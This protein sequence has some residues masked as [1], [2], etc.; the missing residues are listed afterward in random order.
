MNS[1]E[2]SLV[3]SV[4]HAAIGCV[5]CGFEG[6]CPRDEIDVVFELQKVDE[7]WQ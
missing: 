2:L 1:V 6:T 7:C 4:H 5:C 3:E